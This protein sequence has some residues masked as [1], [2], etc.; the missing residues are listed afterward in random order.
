[1]VASL[2]GCCY[3]YKLLIYSWGE[4]KSCVRENWY[5]AVCRSWAEERM[6]AKYLEY[7]MVPL[8]FAVLVSYHLWL[9]ITI[10]RRPK[11]TVIGINAESRRQWVSTMISV[12][13]SLLL[14]SSLP[15]CVSIHINWLFLP[16]DIFFLTSVSEWKLVWN[17]LEFMALK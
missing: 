13:A 5:F 8:G 2:L 10:Y 16:F 11:R 17:S 1:M 7:L 12:S 15:C 6:E 3:C 9:V 14:L 4:A